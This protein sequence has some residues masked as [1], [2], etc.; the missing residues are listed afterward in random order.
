MK[1]FIYIFLCFVPF[2]LNAQLT[3]DFS[4][5]DF[6]NNPIW[7]GTTADFTINVSNQLQT[8]ATVA[9]TSQLT[10]NNL[11]TDLNDVEWRF[12]FKQSFAGSATNYSMIVLTSDTPN[13]LAIQ[14]GYYVLFG[15]AG[16]NDAVRLYKVVNGVK[17]V[18]LS[19]TLGAITN[20]TNA[21]IKIT[22][23]ALGEWKLYVDY[24]GG[25]NYTL[26][27]TATDTDMVAEP[28]FGIL[29]A[30]TVSNIKK[31]YLDDI[32]IGAEQ[33]DNTPPTVISTTILNNKTVKVIFDEP[34]DSAIENQLITTNPT[35][36]LDSISHGNPKEIT[37][38]FNTAFANGTTYSA[39]IPSVKD[40]LGNEA[41][42]PFSFT[43]LV[44]ET[45]TAGD[46]IINE[47]MFDPS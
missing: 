17:T 8:N 15:E 34:I 16:A 30:Y 45:P 21:G 3:E 37:V 35:L 46:I 43:Y 10:T 4:D 13:L 32:Y 23:N 7:G 25:T 39:T 6:T 44:S 2:I 28:Y 20:S 40:L 29:C 18:L 22:H 41:E 12:Y 42:T 47:V 27:G 24:A 19:G 33:V 31:I 38:Y 1:G 36:N 26:E 9:S 14:H 5:G 11:L